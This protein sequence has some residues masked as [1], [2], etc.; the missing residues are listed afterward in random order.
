MPL[1]A[2]T[3]NGTMHE[4]A[5]RLLSESRSVSSDTWQ[6]QP[7]DGRAG[8]D[9]TW[10][11]EDVT[12]ELAIPHT[13]A[14][15]AQLVKPNLPWADVHFEER[16]GGVGVNPP[17]STE[18]WPFK[19]NGH[20]EHT[21][22]GGKFSHTYPER[23]W[24]SHIDHSTAQ[25]NMQDA[26]TIHGVGRPFCD[27][28]E[29]QGIRFP[30]GDLLDVVDLLDRDPLTRQAYLPIWFPEDTG[31]SFNQR[32]PCSLGYQFKY[33][34]GQLNCTYSMRSCDY[35]RHM[36]DDIYMAMRLTEWVA[37][38]MT[39]NFAVSPE[40]LTQY[41][42]PG[43]LVMHI[44]SLHIFDGDKPVLEQL[45]NRMAEQLSQAMMEAMSR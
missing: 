44:G 6:S 23:F 32:V 18:I 34:N 12:L 25:C 21:D 2:R 28:G 36:A 20:V 1:K 27:F 42:V 43:R 31:A 45:V 5:R 37:A 30:Y 14:E 3:Y 24:P 9:R 41:V 39:H 26:S 16:V 22:D 13:A 35:M 11:L 38:Q 33:R 8:M 15:M 40:P 29:L 7:V 19:Q 17:P 4:L 10:E